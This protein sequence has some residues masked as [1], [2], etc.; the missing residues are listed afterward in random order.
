MT[1]S[2]VTPVTLLTGFLGSGK[3]TLLNRLLRD[4]AAADSAVIVNEFGPVA[5]DHALVRSASENVVILPSGCVCCQ[6]A[7]D[8][9]QSLRELYFKRASGE[10]PPFRRAIIETTGLADPAPLLRTLVELPLVAARYSL[11]GVVTTVDGVHGMDQLDRHPEAV[12]QVA[13]ADRLVLTKA[14][15]A[16][17]EDLERLETRLA[18]LNPGARRV[19]AAMGAVEASWLLETGLARGAARLPDPVSWLNA[20]AYRPAGEARAP[21]HDPRIRAFAWWGGTAASLAEVEDALATLL[22]LAGDRILRLKGLAAVA[23][24][25]G[26]VAFHAVQHTLYPPARLAEWPDADRR[27]RFVVIARDLEA[28][29]VA[30]IFDSFV[31]APAREPGAGTPASA[32][33]PR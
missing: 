8:L 19:R 27:T 14:D 3:T 32:T 21:V 7:G 25:P 33:A 17:R 26:P 30:Q 20:G 1:A 24:E 18:E 9:V 16:P 28:A 12:K 2:A 22:E 6:V 11:S 23:G 10:V 13:V 5:I 4:P 31:R 15:Q 29:F